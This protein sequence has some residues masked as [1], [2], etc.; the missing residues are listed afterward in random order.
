MGF[1]DIRNQFIAQSGGVINDNDNFENTKSKSK[2]CIL[3]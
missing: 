1:K 2:K 3:I